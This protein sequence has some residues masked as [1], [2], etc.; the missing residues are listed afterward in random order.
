[1][2][3]RAHR[4]NGSHATIARLLSYRSVAAFLAD[5][6][7]N[8]GRGFLFLNTRDPVDPGTVVHVDLEIA[9]T[10]RK[11]ALLGRVTSSRLE[12][13]GHNESPG[14]TLALLDDPAGSLDAL[15][16]LAARLRL[17]LPRGPSR[18]AS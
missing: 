14:L 2:Q 6:D 1:M 4:S 3:R 7:A 8:L 18:R 17:G 9:G 5:Y 12:G 15:R 13:N 16:A 10:P 11:V